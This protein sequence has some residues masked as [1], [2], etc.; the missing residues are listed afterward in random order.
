MPGVGKTFTSLNLS[1]T[2]SFLDKKVVVIDLDLRK[3]T[4]SKR[5]GIKEGKGVSHYLSDINLSIEEIIHRNLRG[6]NVDYISIG[7]EAPNPVELLLSKRLDQMIAELSNQYDYII[8]DGVPMGIVADAT[9]VDRI[10]DLTLFVVRAGKMDK[11]QLPEIQKIYEEKRLSNLAVIL[12]GIEMG[13]SRYGYGY[14]YGYGYNADEGRGF[15]KR[16]ARKI[17]NLFR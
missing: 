15:G 2:L 9:V 8:I 10:S 12:N 1:N 4:L 6:G 7:T 14:G 3:G 17:R 11:R 13:Q 16:F 5:I